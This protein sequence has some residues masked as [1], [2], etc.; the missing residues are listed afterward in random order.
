VNVY[1]ESYK[2]EKPT[3]RRRLTAVTCY[4][5]HIKQI[6][7]KAGIEVTDGNKREID[8]VIHDIV[9]VDYKNCPDTW[10]EVKKRIAE[11]EEGFV[12]KLK[13]AVTKRE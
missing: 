2:P 4:F 13:E 9:G 10:R 8:R 3:C 5:R 1:P 11:D 12:F 7:I 6:F